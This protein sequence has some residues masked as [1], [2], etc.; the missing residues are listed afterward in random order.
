MNV[1]KEQQHTANEK[2]VADQP[3]SQ[4]SDEQELKKVLEVEVLDI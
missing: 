3:V 2:P 1:E 4:P